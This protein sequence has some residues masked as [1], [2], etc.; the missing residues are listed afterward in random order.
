MNRPNLKEKQFEP[1]PEK[2]AQK[3]NYLTEANERLKFVLKSSG[4]GVWEWNIQTGSFE[5]NDCWLEI[6][7]YT[8]KELKPFSYGD[9]KSFCHPEDLKT[10][11][12][13]FENTLKNINNEFAIDIRLKHK[14]GEWIW[15]HN[16]GKVFKYNEDG[17]PLILLG[18]LKDV[19]F[20][21]VHEEQFRAIFE[22]NATPTAIINYDTTVLLVNEAF[23]KMSAYSKEE[24]IGKKW[25]DYISEDEYERV[26]KINEESIKNISNSP[27]SFQL[28][29]IKKDGS[30]SY[31]LVHLSKI[32]SDN[33]MVVSFLDITK[34]RIAELALQK[35][36][37]RLKK[38][39]VVAH[40]GNWELDLKTNKIWLSDEA[41]NIYG[42]EQNK[43]KYHIDEL[44]GLMLKKDN[45]PLVRSF[46]EI[47]NLKYQNT[48]GYRIKRS[49]DGEIREINSIADVVYS[50]EGEP[51]K[52]I[53]IIHDV[54]EQR[55][56]VR[57]LSQSEEKYRLITENASDVIWVMDFKVKK[58][59]YMSPAIVSLTGFS[60]E[61]AMS[62]DLKSKTIKPTDKKIIN[63]L[64]KDYLVFKKDNKNNFFIDE[65]QQLCKDGK[66][67]WIE[68]SSKFK[69]SKGGNLE[70]IGVSRSIDERKK[71]EAAI[72]QNA[73][74]LKELIATKDKF[75]SIISH[76]LRTP[77]TSVLGMAQMMSDE[78]AG[79]SREEYL[80]LSKYLCTSSAA[81]LGLLEN[82]LH[83]SKLQM[84]GIKFFPETI[85][86]NDFFGTCDYSTIEMAKKKN[87]ELSMS[88]PLGL[89]VPA[90]EN[91]LHSVLRNLVTNAIKFT[92]RG[93]KVKITASQPDENTVMFSVEDN[94]I[95]IE[96][97][98]ME[99]LFRID[100]NVSRPGTDDE[101][102]TGL[103]LI[104][105]KEFV[106][107]HGGKIW[108]ESKED[109]GTTFYFT[110]PEK[111]GEL[112]IN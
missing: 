80:E 22:N 3:N 107:K 38:A 46:K 96:K 8:C 7:G 49:N 15:V 27:S 103:G 18:I 2:K 12:D 55:K 68:I 30:T 88:C 37:M 51:V 20:R 94:G 40:L 13:A 110:I 65:V 109:I 33:K 99:K 74:R 79:F 54:T 76:D 36:E 57:A 25:T 4:I 16:T 1:I 66:V 112:H 75:F 41:V 98:R 92:R 64:E 67:V 82:L 23:C 39:Q 83:W 61:E 56:I 90:D 45:L 86:V 24:A 11:E 47:I 60:V 81:I 102:S 28:S 19:S 93:G 106:E 70:V 105:S 78:K 101:P 48:E 73:R 21:K 29:F 77:I 14:S 9:F 69:Y 100:S 111:S 5:I 91:M 32:K 50:P 62:I 52:I 35:S 85:D 31:G 63:Q 87:I 58:F 53:G 104:L 71:M 97:D 6:I 42:L 84:N 89:K 26:K 17:K 72:L 34:Q 43:F 44:L 59:T 108:V 95:G 10:L